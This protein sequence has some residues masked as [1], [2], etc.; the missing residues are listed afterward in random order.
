MQSLKECEG[1]VFN[2]RKRWTGYSTTVVDNLRSHL[3]LSIS[4]GA[5]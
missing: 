1:L 2:Y 3:F 5:V 4:A